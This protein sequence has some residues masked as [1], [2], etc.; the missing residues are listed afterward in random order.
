MSKIDQEME[1]GE[2]LKNKV[3]MIILIKDGSIIQ[4]ESKSCWW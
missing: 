4:K 1:G 2:F 3:L